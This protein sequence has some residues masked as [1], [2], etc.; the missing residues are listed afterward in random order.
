MKILEIKYRNQ[1]KK[2]SGLKLHFQDGNSMKISAHTHSQ[3]KKE[4]KKKSVT[5]KKINI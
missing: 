1:N 4:K 3:A 5:N 2:L